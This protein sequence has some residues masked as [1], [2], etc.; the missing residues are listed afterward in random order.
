MATFVALISGAAVPPLRKV[1]VRIPIVPLKLRML[2]VCMNNTCFHRL[3]TYHNVKFCNSKNA[4]MS[5]VLFNNAPF[6]LSV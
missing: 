6:Y 4:A 2:R 3:I 1:G 5:N